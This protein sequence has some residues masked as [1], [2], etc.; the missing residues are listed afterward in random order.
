MRLSSIVRMCCSY[1]RLD[2]LD[3]GRRQLIVIDLRAQPHARE[4]KL[5]KVI[6][7]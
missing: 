2:S 3:F 1:D 5:I 7:T 6:G 4:G